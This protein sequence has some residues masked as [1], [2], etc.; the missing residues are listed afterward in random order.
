VPRRLRDDL[1][2]VYAFCRAVDDLG[3]E[4]PATPAE[5]LALLDAWQRDTER[6]FDPGGPAPEDSR[7]AALADTAARHRL[8]PEP[9][10]RLIEANRIDQRRSRWDTADELLDYCSYSATPV[11]R[12]VLAL[13]GHRDRWRAGLSDRTC[14][15]LQLANFWQDVRRDLE[16]RDRVYLPRRDMERFGVPE[17][18]LRL[19]S[20]TPALRDL[21]A[22]E[23]DV[24]RAHLRAGAP[25]AH[26]CGP[27][28]ALDLRMFT[29]G[30]LAVCDA[31][32][33]QGYDVLRRRPAPGRLGRARIALGA[34]ARIARGE[35]A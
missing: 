24:A 4:G 18:D 12:I 28:A 22:F 3:D 5:R 27:R 34:L 7:L 11:G 26:V 21:L 29:A 35:A 2:A 19:P 25:L 23:V 20:A 14:I 32:A 31:I 6:A 10:L 13:L 33:R 9:F 1:R 17:A 15:G 30:G 16:D 8:D